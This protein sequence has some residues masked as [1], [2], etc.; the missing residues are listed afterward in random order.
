[1]KIHT[2]LVCRISYSW[3]RVTGK[4]GRS[5]GNPRGWPQRHGVRG[6]IAQGVGRGRWCR[7]E[8]KG[9][10]DGRRV[11]S[12]I[13]SLPDARPAT[14]ALARRL[15]QH[16]RCSGRLARAGRAGQ[17]HRGGE[18]VR[19]SWMPSI[20]STDGFRYVGKA[21]RSLRPQGDCSEG[22]YSLVGTGFVVPMSVPVVETGQ[23]K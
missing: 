17:F 2:Y 12:V 7:R 22:N 16:F 3:C 23:G 21:V 1:M 10:Q 4:R 5:W 8:L 13:G 19:D 14:G 15:L 18:S 11:R 6:V 20:K 9:G